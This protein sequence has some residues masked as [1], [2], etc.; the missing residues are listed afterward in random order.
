MTNSSHSSNAVRLSDGI[1]I[2][3]PLALAA[4][5]APVA[6]VAEITE[7]SKVA[8][9]LYVYKSQLAPIDR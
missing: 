4:G 6:V 1:G 2:A 8:R 7:P 5:Y 9:S 3:Q